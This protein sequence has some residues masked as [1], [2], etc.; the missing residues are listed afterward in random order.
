MDLMDQRFHEVPSRHAGLIGDHHGLEFVL[1]QQ[2]NGVLDPREEPESVDMVH[3]PDF[4]IN[5][6]IAIKKYGPVCHHP[7]RSS[8]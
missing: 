6:T 5:R 4:F 1:V 2:S 3:I 7:I 8:D